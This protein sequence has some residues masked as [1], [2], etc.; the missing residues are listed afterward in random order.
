MN[1]DDDAVQQLVA[2]VSTVLTFQ[3][4]ASVRSVWD[5]LRLAWQGGN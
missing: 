3:G 5:R 4:Y 1:V 2:L